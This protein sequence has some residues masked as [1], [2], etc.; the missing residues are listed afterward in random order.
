VGV[1]RSAGNGAVGEA[2]KA[3]AKGMISAPAPGGRRSA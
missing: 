1:E 2:R 3:A